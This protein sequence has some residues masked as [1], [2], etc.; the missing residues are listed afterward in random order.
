MTAIDLTLVSPGVKWHVAVDHMHDV[1]EKERAVL[2]SMLD[3][4]AEGLELPAFPQEPLVPV[5]RDGP[6]VDDESIEDRAA[7]LARK[8]E[9]RRTRNGAA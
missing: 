3:L 6:V 4:I 2:G 1:N 7:M 5:E 9:E 8:R